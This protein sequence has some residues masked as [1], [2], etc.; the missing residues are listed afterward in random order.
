MQVAEVISRYEHILAASG[1]MALAAEENRW[2]DLINLEIAR[3]DLINDVTAESATP[4]AD[5]ALQARKE[6]LIRAIL[7]ADEQ[8]KSLTATWM[9][10]MEG[11]LTSVQA[12][13]K[14]ARAYETG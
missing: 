10:E 5:A 6:T 7:A 8:V 13:R 12:E 14:L 3:R 4:F 11:I 2:E 9:A 1:E